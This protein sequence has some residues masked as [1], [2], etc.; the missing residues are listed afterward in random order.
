DDGHLG[1]VNVRIEN[2]G[3][4]VVTDAG[5]ESA[6]VHL[7]GIH[8][9]AKDDDAQVKIGGLTINAQDDQATIR[10]SRDV[11]LKGEAFSREKRGVR[12]TFIYTGKNLP[13]GYR[14]VGY[15]AAGPKAGP[16]A[17]AVVKSKDESTDSGDV[18]GDVKKLVRRN[19]GV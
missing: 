2:D 10:I 12:A 18:Y 11:R 13:G 14:L 1:E 17:V 5:G 9:D 8:I 6:H 4:T 15:E 16:L 19:G 3:K 7:P